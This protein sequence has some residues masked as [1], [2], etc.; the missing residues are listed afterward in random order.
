MV[1]FYKITVSGSKA[2]NGTQLVKRSERYLI[3]G[4]SYGERFGF[5]TPLAGMAA[6]ER[7]FD[8]NEA[9]RSR[10]LTEWTA[11]G[12]VPTGEQTTPARPEAQRDG[13]PLKTVSVM[14]EGDQ[15]LATMSEYVY[16]DP[17]TDGSPTDPSYFAKLNVKQ[18]RGHHFKSIPL[19]TAQTGDI[20]TLAAYFSSSSVA[21]ISTTE[22][23]YSQSY[24]ERGIP[25]RPVLSKKL[26][27]V[28]GSVLA[29]TQLVYDKTPAPNTGT[30]Y[31]IINA[32]TSPTWQDPNSDFRGNVTTSRTWVKETDTWLETH[33][34]FDNFGNLRFSWDASGDSNKYVETEYSSEY[35]YAYPTKVITPAPDPSHTTGTNQTSSSETTYDP[36]TG[37]V[38]T[39]TDDFGQIIRN[40]YNDPLLRLKKTYGENFTAPISETIYDDDALTVKVRKQIDETNWDEAT[41]HIRQPWPHVQNGRQGFAGRCDRRNPLRSFWAALDRVT[42]PYRAGRYCLLE[43]D[44]I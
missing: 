5:D 1:N 41:S 37:L 23:D 2:D 24:W 32:G 36:I 44:E 6:E 8:D 10:T 31:P 39:V 21:G 26:S 15:A 17:T 38:L 25:S 3:K 34:Q 13:R 35:N 22:Y 16:Q 43:Q 30:T 14:I 18:K 12:P 7:T 9:L 4:L 40:E 33:A 29:Q 19:S 28:D 20:A 27:P 42:N 11:T